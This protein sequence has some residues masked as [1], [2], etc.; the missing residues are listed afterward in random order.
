MVIWLTAAAVLLVI[1]A[2]QAT[3]PLVL[4]AALASGYRPR[5]AE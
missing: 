1:L 2:P 3:V 4:L 5:S